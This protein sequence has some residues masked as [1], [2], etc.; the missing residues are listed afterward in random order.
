V[1]QLYISGCPR[2][3]GAPRWSL[4]GFQR[5]HLAVGESREV[6][7]TVPAAELAVVDEN[8]QRRMAP[9]RYTVY[10][11]GRQGDSRSR[12][13]AG[14]EVLQG[15]FEIIGARTEGESK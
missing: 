5:I 1:V 12:E 8:G 11:G 7:L 9:G 2:I 4:K 13:L 14:T 10:V 3:E 6:T 15:E